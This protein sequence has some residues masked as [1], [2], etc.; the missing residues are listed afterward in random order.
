[1]KNRLL[2]SAFILFILFPILSASSVEDEIQKITHYA[3]EYETGNIN[4]VKLQLYLSSVKQNL[5]GLLGVSDRE[6]GGLMNE[7]QI[8]GVLGEPTE[9]TGWAWIEGQNKEERLEEP[10]PA[11]NKIIFDG[12]KIQI[13]L[14]AWPSLFSKKISKIERKIRELEE[15]GEN[16]EEIERLKKELND[17]SDEGIL[18]YRLHFNVEFKRPQEQL[19]IQSRISDVQQLA[20]EFNVNPSQE[21]AETLAKE[22]VNTERAFESY[23][24]QGQEQCTDLMS[25]IFGSEN[26]RS[27][28]KLIVKEAVFYSGENFDAI[29]RLEMCDDCEWH[30]ININ[31]WIEFRGFNMQEE[32]SGFESSPD[33]YKNLEFDDFEEKIRNLIDDY[34]NAIENKDWKEANKINQKIW[35]LSDAWGQKSND[36]WKVIEP[37]FEAKRQAMTQEQQNEYYSNYGWIKDE[38]E[39]RKMV[40][41]LAKQNYEKRKTFYE[42]LL[43]NYDLRKEFYFEQV[44]FEKRLVEE[45]KEFGKEICDNNIDDNKNEQIDCSESQ[46]G[47]KICGK[48]TV[49]II[50]SNATGTKTVDLYC[51]AGTCQQKEEIIEANQSICGNNICEEGEASNA[52]QNGTCLQDCTACQEYPA[53]SCTGRVIFSGTDANGC[54]LEPI[55]LNETES[56]TADQDCFQPLC[57]ISSCIENKCQVSA[58]TEC[59]ESECIDGKERRVHCDSGEDIIIDICV[60]GLWSQTNI[61]CEF[62]GGVNETGEVAEEEIVG[63][64]CIVRSDCGG[65]NDVCS[66]GRCVTIPQATEIIDMGEE[67]NAIGQEESGVENT[68]EQTQEETEQEADQ[69]EQAV[70]SGEGV[71]GNFIFNFFRSLAGKITGAFITGL[72]SEDGSS[73]GSSSDTSNSGSEETGK[74]IEAIEGSDSGESNRPEP[75]QSPGEWQEQNGDEWEERQRQEDEERDREDD[76]RR[77]DERD[78]R[79][80]EC[81]ERCDREC[82]DM[83]IRPCVE[84]CI[85]KECGQNFECNAD[86]VKNSCESSCKEEKDTNVCKEECN[87]KCM[88]GESTWKEPEREQHKEEKGV[89]TV[90]GSCRTAKG[91]TEGFIW[92][93]GWGD[94]FQRIQSLKTKYYSGGGDWCKWDLENLK[95]QREEFEQ[96]FNQQ[97]IEW[98]FNSYLANSAEDWESHISGIFELYWRDVDLSRE[99]ANRMKCLNI[100]EL[101]E[102]TLIGPLK[103]ESSYGSIEFWEEITLGSIDKE[104]EPVPLITPYM[105]VWVFPSEEVIKFEMKKA[106]KEHRMPGPP[107]EESNQGPGEQEKEFMRQD[108]DFME[109]IE[110]LSEKYDGDF[111]SA[112]QIADPETNEIVFNAHIKI[113]SDDLM[114]ISPMLPEENSEVDATVKLD[115]NKLYDI[116]S[117]EEKEMSGIHV[118]SPPWAPKRIKPIQKIK[119]VTSG[120]KM[121]FKMKSFINSAEI[122]PSSAEDDVNSILENVMKMMMGGPDGKS[123]EGEPEEGEEP[124]E[125]EISAWE[126]KET[127]T[128]NV[129]G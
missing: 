62:G 87:G 79:E 102:Y 49:E 8:E 123:P 70:E 67:Q 14:E 55:C 88:K 51:I 119:E 59:R 12:K 22:S 111:S 20:Q 114:A 46:C 90:G 94:P 109:N 100:K 65:E 91:K 116:I 25:S 68:G 113:N 54:S 35:A 52:F 23:I 33:E 77:E 38:Q 82:Y 98:F 53:L 95:K 129:I 36:V 76:E 80:N 72:T 40:Q 37:I 93:G 125:E 96:G 75:S 43:S 101:P 107:E 61:E 29:A 5:N 106:M 9:E 115:F 104:G 66:N 42:S 110:R 7:A 122:S 48:E 84:E 128:G 3:E 15:R 120:I 10:A 47:G 44:S 97:F 63:T 45:F 89:F 13:R 117:I 78:R 17:G 39:K 16:L 73:E 28:E 57:G 86:E 103:Y 34:K 18:V 112:F 21:N 19:D 71:T 118:E 30:W 50:E 105:K 2:V 26:R 69:N 81:Q 60:D 83:E 124:G 1:M 24:R 92:F 11:W 64:E 126:S 41:E 4:Y 31:F 127:L 74:T 108:R 32:Q 56:C 6:D 99:M 58:L 121:Y 85:F 27:T